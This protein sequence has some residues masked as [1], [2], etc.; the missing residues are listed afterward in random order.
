MNEDK[1]ALKIFQ[2]VKFFW[3]TRN[4]LDIIIVEHK[5]FNVTE[6]IAYEPT[7][8]REAPRVYLNTAVLFTKIDHAAVDAQVSFAKRNNVP[9]TEEWIEGIYNKA[10]ADYLL[11]RLF[12]TDFSSDDKL[13]K[14]EIQISSIEVEADA[15]AVD[16]TSLLC[17]RPTELRPF[18]SSHYATLM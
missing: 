11:N 2:G 9:H 10:K 8:D 1:N 13:I 17:A 5:S 15:E 18:H 7:I 12:I 4:S 14:V 16:K 6:L 3:R